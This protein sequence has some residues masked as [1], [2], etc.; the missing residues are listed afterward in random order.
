MC[1]SR[2]VTCRPRPTVA[3][4]GA[5]GFKLP[6]DLRLGSSSGPPT[7]AGA[8]AGP[9]LLSVRRFP[10]R[11]CSLS[12]A[13]ARPSAGAGC[14]V[15][16]PGHLARAAERALSAAPARPTRPRAWLPV[17]RAAASPAPCPNGSSGSAHTRPTPQPTVDRV[18]QAVADLLWLL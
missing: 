1:I 18:L 10:A 2:G 11:R 16:G 6:T 5:P 8:G 7:P 13:S 15:A 4:R 3:A 14:A 17:K 9:G 12:A